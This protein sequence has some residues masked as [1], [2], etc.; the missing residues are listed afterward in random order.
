MSRALAV[1]PSATA[2][3]ERDD[4]R[5][6]VLQRDGELQAARERLE[7][8]SKRVEDQDAAVAK[9]VAERDEARA[10]VLERDPAARGRD[11]EHVEISKRNVLRNHPNLG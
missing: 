3:R 8:V 6:I 4:A 7:R 10:I 5:Q 11:A 9:V 1:A 2:R